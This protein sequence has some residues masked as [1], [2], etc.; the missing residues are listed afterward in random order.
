ME[1]EYKQTLEVESTDA[2]IALFGLKD[3][4]I[5]LIREEL[6]VEVFVHGTQIR[7]SGDEE[8]VEIAKVALE[9]LLEK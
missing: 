2:Y 4:N 1:N 8:K 7:L 6:G 5:A 9:K 3:E